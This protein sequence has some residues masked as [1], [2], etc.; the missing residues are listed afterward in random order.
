MKKTLELTIHSTLWKDSTE[1]VNLKDFISSKLTFR[2][3]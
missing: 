3:Q 2:T 1:L